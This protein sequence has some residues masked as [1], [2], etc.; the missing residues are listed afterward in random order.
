MQSTLGVMMFSRVLSVGAAV[1]TVF[2]FAFESHAQTASLT[3]AELPP[4]SF[5]GTQYTDSQGCTFIRASYGGQVSWVP[6]FGADRLPVCNQAPTDAL[7]AAPVAGGTAQTAASDTITMQTPT[8]QSD[9]IPADA[10]QPAMVQTTAVQ[11]LTAAPIQPRLSVMSPLITPSVLNDDPSVGLNSIGNSSY[12]AGREDIVRFN[13]TFQQEPAPRREAVAG[14]NPACPAAQPFGQLVRRANGRVAVRC[15]TSADQLLPVPAGHRSGPIVEAAGAPEV[16]I[17]AVPRA[18]DD[19]RYRTVWDDGRLNP[20]RAR[21]T[22]EGQAAMER[23]WS[24]DVPQS[25]LPGFGRPIAGTSGVFVQVA[26]FA[27]ST[28]AR[29]TSN[30]LYARGLPIQVHRTRARGRSMQVVLAGPYAD[31]IDAQYALA[32]ARNMGFR[33]AFIRR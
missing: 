19:E 1:A 30:A 29:D 3:P 4:V 17:S 10:E 13:S 21:D 23:N 8:M 14:Y 25:E 33:D 31:T 24:Q 5:Q 26:T 2:V 18:T 20:G 12:A 27:Q 16:R 22:A 6:R 15:V 11:E 7:A 28:N 32:T 9:T